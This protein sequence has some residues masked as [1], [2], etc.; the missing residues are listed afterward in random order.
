MLRLI[1]N[2][3]HPMT[4]TIVVL[5]TGLSWAQM[6]RTVATSAP[7]NVD[8]VEA[9]T[10]PSGDVTLAFVRPG[11]IARILV[12]EGQSVRTGELLAQQDDKAEQAQI[13]QLKAQ[14]EDTTRVK[15]AQAQLEQKRVDLAKLEKGRTQGAASQLEVEHA[16]LDVKIAELSLDLANFEHGQDQRKLAESVAQVERMRIICPV[17]GRVEKLLVQQGELADAQNS[18][19]VHVVKTD[20]LWIDA[21]V[22]LDL[23]RPLCAGRPATVEFPTGET[24]TGKV[25]YCGSLADAASNTLTV[26]VEVPNP[27]GRV[28]GEH[29]KLRFARGQPTTAPAAAQPVK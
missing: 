8:A 25:A 7:A 28:A 27:T 16:A 24:A 14:A 12:K 10:K 3:V 17:D 18:K 23:A 15:A 2:R 9:I 20:P 26:R 5:M 11:I 13:D 6:P 1:G 22:P 29:V 21:P 19:V 4:A